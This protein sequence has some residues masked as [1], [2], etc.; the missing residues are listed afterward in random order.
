MTGPRRRGVAAVVAVQR[1]HELV[2][3]LR[4]EALQAL[5]RVHGVV[6]LGRRV[7][8]VLPE[9]GLELEGRA[10]PHLGLGLGF[11]VRVMV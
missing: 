2:Q 9:L 11:R 4:A 1:L 7:E 3:V 8:D 10:L 6:V 5:E